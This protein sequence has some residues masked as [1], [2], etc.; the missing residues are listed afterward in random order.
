MLST[1]SN[2]VP[3]PFVCHCVARPTR[4]LECIYAWRCAPIARALHSDC[5]K[6]PCATSQALPTTCSAIISMHRKMVER[7]ERDAEIATC[8]YVQHGC[9]VNANIHLGALAKKIVFANKK[10]SGNA[11]RHITVQ[12]M[13][14]LKACTT[15]AVAIAITAAAAGLMPAVCRAMVICCCIITIIL[16]I[17]QQLLLLVFF[18]II[19]L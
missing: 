12:Y 4:T 13:Y 6:Q 8:E 16:L 9:K 10:A 15:A 3:F 14:D 5:K 11:K 18:L 7:R 17:Y 1:H 2:Y 19:H